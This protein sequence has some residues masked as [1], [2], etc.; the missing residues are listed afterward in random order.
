M[1]KYP[2][3]KQQR[4]SIEQR[5]FKRKLKLNNAPNIDYSYKTTNK[6]CSC[7]LCSPGKVEDKAKYRYMNNDVI[8]GVNDFVRG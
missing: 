8:I 7:A 3:D 2:I 6:P 1:A 5:K 4:K